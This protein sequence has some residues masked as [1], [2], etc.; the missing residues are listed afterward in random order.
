MGRLLLENHPWVDELI[1]YPTTRKLLPAERRSV[2]Q[3][4]CDTWALWKAEVAFV[5]ALR[6]RRF[7]V[8]V[9]AMSNPRTALTAWASGA[10]FR[11]SFRSRFPRT[12]AFHHLVPRERLTR[13]YV[14]KARLSL[15]EPWGLDSFPALESLLP[16]RP[17][18]KER[19]D[20]FLAKERLLKGRFVV[21]APAHRH[22]VRKWPAAKYAQLAQEI[23]S[24]HGLR[25]V[26]LWG[27]G[28]EAEMRALEQLVHSSEKFQ[29]ASVVPPLLSLR[30]TADLAGRSCC[31]VGN[32]NGLSHVAVAGGARSVQIHGPTHAANWTFPD[33]TRH[34]GVQRN[35][36]CVQCEK[37]VCALARRE[38]LDD[39]DVSVVLAAVER[40][41]GMPCS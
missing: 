10:A 19:V 40:L 11:V 16:L 26:W 30:E 20:A 22:A 3:R 6:A 23:F 24:R 33:A 1:C 17:E 5:L 2:F 36:G 21:C 18:E 4:V 13:G 27:P 35:T 31:F 29:G 32:S 25:T 28:E 37:N 7:D 14:A 39:L 15:L 41:A 38:C 8:A 12:L 34:V 9:D